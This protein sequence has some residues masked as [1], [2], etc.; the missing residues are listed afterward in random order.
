MRS[1]WLLRNGQVLAAADIAEGL[2]DRSRGLMGR[3][4]FEHALVLAPALPA[5]TLGVSYAVGVAFLDRGLRV[6][7]AVRLSPWRIARPR[8]GCKVV[9]LAS[10]TSF[11]RWRLEVGDVLEVCE[12]EAGPSGGPPL[13][14]GP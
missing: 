6:I 2:A 12:V 3:P 1:G 14:P 7:D 8:R 10:A 9:V 11:E 5:H 13:S 4:G